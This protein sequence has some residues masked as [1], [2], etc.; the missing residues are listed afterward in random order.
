VGEAAGHTDATT[1]EG[2]GPASEAWQLGAALAGLANA[3]P[4]Q[5]ARFVHDW[6]NRP[7]E[8]NRV[9]SQLVARH[10]LTD[11]QVFTLMA[12][13]TQRYPGLMPLYQACVNHDPQ[14]IRQIPWST[15]MAV[16]A[17]FIKDRSV[18]KAGFAIAKDPLLR[19]T[20]ARRFKRVFN[21]S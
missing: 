1:G 14:A 9:L 15:I 10:L 12:G 16:G 18:V 8:L 3:T 17:L 7:S 2:I 21:R 11:P 19:E 6:N 20:V 4:A 13:L 5:K